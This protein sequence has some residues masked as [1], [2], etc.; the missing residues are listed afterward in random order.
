MPP[1]VLVGL[2]LRSPDNRVEQGLVL[3]SRIEGGSKK[4]G[5]K[6]PGIGKDALDST[7]LLAWRL[8]ELTQASN[9]AK[10]EQPSSEPS[11]FLLHVK[12]GHSL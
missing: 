3:D 4:F 12:L 1:P 11:M 2:R 8:G 5:G 6:L 9:V 10:D 7:T